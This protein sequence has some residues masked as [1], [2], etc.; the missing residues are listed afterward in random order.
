M[1]RFPVVVLVVAF[2]GYLAA[3]EPT[4]FPDAK[5][6]KGELTHVE[7][8]PVV[9][10]RGTPTEMGEQF[11]VLAMKNAPGLDTLQTNFLRDSGIDKRFGF[12]KI[13]SRKLKAGMP[14]DHVTEIEAAVKASGRD[15]DMSLF[16]NSVYDL[17][18]GMGC[19]TV[20]VEKNRSKTGAPIFGRNFDWLPSKG[21]TEHTLLA[22]F[23]PEGKRSFAIIT[24]SPI[25]GCISGMNDAGLACTI[26]EIHLKQS[27]EKAEFDVTGTPTMLAFRRV[28]EECGSVAEAEKL[29][30]GM[31]RTTSACLTIC[32]KDGGA[33]FEITPKSIVVRSAV[34]DV[35]CCTNHFRTDLLGKGE[36]CWRYTALEPLQSETMKL[37]VADVF[38]QLHEVHQKKLTLQSMVF[39]PAERKL[40]LKYGAGP[41]T[42]LQA[43]TFDL[44]KWF[45]K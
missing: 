11:G 27:K 12:V 8:M 35:C 17:S 6:G 16:A 13:L 38:A 2:G 26:N 29:L 22:V 21:I 39:E 14:A 15:L 18:S 44:G 34:N 10:L 5:H 4:T 41:A 31:K 32:D 9:F 20:V 42:T 37:G 28:L 36:K 3:A 40:H 45:G 1:L 30:R 25:V 43:K 7:G 24:I 19:S 33:V 23:Q